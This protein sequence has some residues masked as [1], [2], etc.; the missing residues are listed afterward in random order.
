MPIEYDKNQV[1]YKP[2]SEAV[3]DAALDFQEDL[4]QNP[5]VKPIADFEKE[6]LENY[7]KYFGYVA[8]PFPLL[9]IDPNA[10]V[11]L[12]NIK[13]LFKAKGNFGPIR[14]PL[15]LQTPN[16]TKQIGYYQLPNM[17]MVTVRGSKN[18]VITDVARG[19]QTNGRV[20]YGTV[21]EDI[22]LRDY[23]IDI[24]G[25]IIGEREGELPVNEIRS[26]KMFC[27]YGL[28]LDVEHVLLNALD[29]Y[30]LKITDFDFPTVEGEGEHVQTY[31]IKALSDDDFER[32]LINP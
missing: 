8:P 24:Q 28:S 11:P 26:I 18:I 9:G 16:L 19:M 27:E 3:R 20:R 7:I 5:L 2:K 21:K 25:I 6:V 22:H 30:K 29:I 31:I 17:P 15:G 14:Q 13:S 12:R 1:R 4:L 23:Q 32:D 10:L